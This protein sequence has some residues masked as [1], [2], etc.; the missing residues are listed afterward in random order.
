MIWG[1][2]LTRSL[3]IWGRLFSNMALHSASRVGEPMMLPRE[4]QIS[5]K[6]AMICSSV[7][8]SVMKLSR[9]VMTSTQ[10]LQV[11]SLVVLGAARAEAAKAEM[12]RANFIL[13]VFVFTGR[14][15][16]V[17]VG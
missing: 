10:M 15:L 8:A 3:M 5:L 7:V 6:K 2:L 17:E 12:R 13:L 4:W 14:L 11:S 9:S 16:L 1:R